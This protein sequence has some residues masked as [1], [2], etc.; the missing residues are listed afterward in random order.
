MG[1]PK[2]KTSQRMQQN[3]A[4]NAAKP[5]QRMHKS[6]I[7]LVSDFKGISLGFSKTYCILCEAYYILC[8]AYCILCEAYC[9][10]CEAYYILC[11]VVGGPNPVILL[12]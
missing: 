10:L 11:E 1:Q 5:S 8:E 9:I 7:I 3:L 2:Q 12:Y 4:E 6:C